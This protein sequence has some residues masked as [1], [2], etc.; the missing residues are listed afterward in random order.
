MISAYLWCSE[1]A[2][3]RNLELLQAIAQAIKQI[4]G[5]WILAADFNFPPSVLRRTGWLEL[6]GGSIH[7]AA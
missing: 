4:H 5:P 3:T 2:S 7:N 1:G 6:V